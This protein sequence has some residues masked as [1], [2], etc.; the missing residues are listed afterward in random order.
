MKIKPFFL[1][2]L[3]GFSIFLTF[4]LT[5]INDE[6]TNERIS[7]PKFPTNPE[8]PSSPETLENPKI[9]EKINKKPLEWYYDNLTPADRKKIRQAMDMAIPRDEILYGIADGWGISEITTPIGPQVSY[10]YDPSILART[11]DLSG[12]LDLLEQVFGYRYDVN[13]HDET[14]DPYFHM[15]IAVPTTNLARTQWAALISRS[16]GRIGIDV[17][18]KWLN[19]NILM[20]RLFTDPVG[21]GFDYK[22]GGHD[23]YFIGYGSRQLGGMNEH[24]KG[25]DFSE[26]YLSSKFPPDGEN[27]A[28]IAVAAVDD[29]WDTAIHSTSMT[30]RIQALKDFQ[31]WFYDE[32]P[33]SIIFQGKDVYAM[34]STLAGFDPLHGHNFQNWTLAQPDVTYVQR[35]NFT[36]FNPLFTTGGARPDLSV[37]ESV[38]GSLTKMRG[39]HNLTHPVGFLADSWSHSPDFLTWDVN[40][41]SGVLWHDGTEVTA[42][43]VVFTYKAV[44]NDSLNVDANLKELMT[45]IFGQASNIEKVDP[46]HVRFYLPDFHPFVE[47]LGFGLTILQKAQLEPLNDWRNHGTNRGT[48]PLQGFGPYYF[49]GFN[50]TTVTLSK[51][52][53]YN[54]LRM[55][56]NPSAVGG[57]IWWPNASIA[58]VYVKHVED[59]EDAFT[60]LEAGK[61]DVI[62][63]LMDIN[64]Y[65]HIIE[66]SSWGK[67]VETPAWGWQE[68]SYNQYS[69]IWGMNPEDPRIT[70]PDPLPETENNL[71]W[72]Y[73]NL[74]PEDRK[75]VRQAMDMAI[76]RDYIIEQI[77]GGF[78]FKSATPFDEKFAG[79]HDPS[80]QPR[81]FDLEEAKILL[82][83]VFGYRYIE[84][85][86]NGSEVCYF[87]MTLSAPTSRQD[88]MRWAGLTALNFQKI[89]INITLKLW[90]WGIGMDRIFSDPAGPGF[91]YNHGGFDA[92]F[93]GWMDNPDHDLR[94]WYSSDYW[95]PDSSNYIW[96]NDPTADDICH[97]TWY[98]PDLD[99]RIQAFKDFQV[100]YHNEVP[101]SFIRQGLEFWALD[102]NLAG[103]DP[104][105]GY[106]VQNWTIGAQTSAVIAQPADFVNFN[107]LLA[108]SYYDLHV[109]D[110]IYCSLSRI[111]GIN[112]FT[113]AVPWLA[114]SWTHSPDYLTWDVTLRSGIKWSDG[115]EVTA[116]D[117]VFTYQAVMNE[118]LGSRNQEIR[119]I[120]GDVNNIIK[121]G[122]YSVRF[123]LPEFHPHVETV[124]FGLDILQKDQMEAISFPDWITHDTNI[125]YSPVGC[126]PYQFDSYD[127]IDT[128]VLKANPYYNQ[129][130]MGHDPNMIG[131][132]NW[133]PNST[134]TTVTYKVVKTAGTAIAG[135]ESGT[136]DMIDKEMGIQGWADEI[137]TSPWGKLVKSSEWGF[138]ELGYNQ[139]SP[140]WG[141]NPED[142]QKMYPL[143]YPQPEFNL[144]SSSITPISTGVYQ[145]AVSLQNDGAPTTLGTL[146]ISWEKLYYELPLVDGKGTLAES[147]V[148]LD[149]NGDEDKTDTFDVSWWYSETRKWD[150]KISGSHVYSL[151]EGPSEAPWSVQTYYRHGKSKLFTLGNMTH[152]LYMADNNVAAF[153]LGD[154]YIANHPSPNFLLYCN[155]SDIHATDF[156]INGDSVAINHT[157]AGRGIYQG[158]D[159]NSRIYISSHPQ[160]VINTGDHVTFTCKLI[161]HWRTTP[162]DLI[163]AVNWSPDSNTRLR[164]VP[165]SQELLVELPEFDLLDYSLTQTDAY[166]DTYVYKFI[167]NINNTGA[168]ATSGTIPIFWEE[169]YFELPLVN[170][171]GRLDESAVDIDLN[172][173]GD[174]YDSFDVS[175][176]HN[177]TRMFDAI[178]S[179]IHAYSIF[180][181]PP[182]APW[183]HRTYYLDTGQAKLFQLGSETH[184]LYHAG[185][186]IAAFGFNVINNN[187]PSP[188]F[189][190]YFN[191]L[192]ITAYNFTINWVYVEEDYTWIGTELLL[193]DTIT[194]PQFINLY[195][196]PDYRYQDTTGHPFEVDTGESI[197]FTCN[198]MV[199]EPV[200]C[201]LGLVMNWSPDGNTRCIWTPV[202]EESISLEGPPP[203]AETTSVLIPTTPPEETT[204]K[205]DTTVEKMSETKQPVI[206]PSPGFELPVILLV[207]GT[208][209]ILYR[210]IKRK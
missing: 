57:S 55:G 46:Y 164:R 123:T 90:E 32:V 180:E 193:G 173:D 98:Q 7:A 203:P 25:I 158:M 179:G 6:F 142:P 93:I 182:E 115:T 42:D 187:H 197:T 48:T 153:G 3:L 47:S 65:Y 125:K 210:K 12:A 105:L 26:L 130:K 192:S 86:T 109:L 103:F 205:E 53:M 1:L 183:T 4:N 108:D 29:I 68:L 76:P 37:S 84:G 33:K 51:A 181:G 168:P 17:D 101:K 45:D 73:D 15:T 20:P 24:T 154:V 178:I 159:L 96:L 18:L 196:L 148:D 67:I 63:P 121:T 122:T 58:T 102:P 11:Y 126:G 169:M 104:Y 160:L 167:A 92:F 177:E 77:L 135:L 155:T 60:K 131:G 124:F 71:E 91:D 69:P 87:D 35:N 127:F 85:E 70:Y 191:T 78:A 149:L 166:S 133:V 14:R 113:H 188:N 43:D 88:R 64:K 202:W 21:T 152:A 143:D 161:G 198:L 128:V 111:R 129:L 136:Y 112:N 199:H 41:N 79:I 81:D 165:F 31:A 94:S 119:D 19:W 52:D 141:I 106:N 89:G 172:G 49:N 186:D 174:K 138:Q 13:A 206:G 140:I 157:W 151:C 120:L 156:H 195:L 185:N 39:E 34:N 56:H 82:Q 117:I 209:V 171:E 59:P 36:N 162:V 80:I 100:W 114:A 28:W 9:S 23:A 201:T 8:T 61:Y 208:G 40:L 146:P 137:E 95:V 207:F 16:F 118:H 5:E 62:D 54:D 30:D 190:L 22:H 176:F 110:N 147:I 72:Y 145:L 107:P 194:H 139:F 116:D 144:I 134:L 150:A 184:F 66:S 44:F 50:G 170:G 38:H 163:L 204:T 175:W 2:I 74:T 132:G 189:E 97:R 83:D 27:A 75:K 200:D 99:D 10:A